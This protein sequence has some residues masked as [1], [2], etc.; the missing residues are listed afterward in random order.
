MFYATLLRQDPTNKEV[1]KRCYEEEHRRNWAYA[2]VPFEVDRSA[3]MRFDPTWSRH[4]RAQSFIKELKAAGAKRILDIGC[5]AVYP[6]IFAK[7]GFEVTGFDVSEEALS[8]ARGLAE[9]WVVASMVMTKQGYAQELPFKEGEFDS[10]VMGEVLEHVP[11]P[12]V[13]LAEAMR[14]VKPGGIV[15]ASTPV[16]EHH[17]DPFHIASERGGWNDE[18]IFRLLEPWKEKV[19]K[20]E[21]IAEEGTDPS[22]YLIVVRK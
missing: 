12:D 16:G 3:P 17:F 6:T 20:V 22:C 4:W 5:A 10:V 2:Q 8:Q 14:V 19:V 13:C 7:E 15:L 1:V 18:L 21:T 9:K 11:D